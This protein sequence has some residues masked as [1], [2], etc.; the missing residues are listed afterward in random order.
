MALARMVM[1]LMVMGRMVVD[2]PGA[3]RFSRVK[4]RGRVPQTTQPLFQRGAGGLGL[5]QRQRQRL[6]G[7]TGSDLGGTG[8]LSDHPLH[9][10]GA[11]GTVHA[12]H[13]VGE[14]FGGG[15]LRLGHALS[16]S[17]YLLRCLGIGSLRKPEL[18]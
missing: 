7:K 2:S 12:H 15:C 5:I 16:I 13:K 1:A 14:L 11:V 3:G 6:T 8:Q 18:C 17:E 9:F 10:R 4:Q